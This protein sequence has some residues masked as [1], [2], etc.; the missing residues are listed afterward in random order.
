MVTNAAIA[1][2]LAATTVVVITAGIA[3][4]PAGADIGTPRTEGSDL[5]FV[6]PDGTV[7]VIPGGAVTA[8]ALFVGDTEIPDDVLVALFDQNGIQPAV[9]PAGDSGAHGNFEAL[10]PQSVGQGSVDRLD[11]LFDDAGSSFDVPPPV[12][13]QD[14]GPSQTLPHLALDLPPQGPI[15]NVASIGGVSVGAITEDA[16]PGIHETFTGADELDWGENAFINWDDRAGDFLSEYGRVPGEQSVSKTFDTL[17]AGRLELSFDLL[18]IDA[19]SDEKFIIFLDNGDAFDFQPSAWQ[20]NASGSFVTAGGLTGSYVITLAAG[21]DLVGN[22]TSDSVYHVELIIDGAGDSLTV[23]FG[24][25]LEGDF[26]QQDFGIDNIRLTSAELRADGQLTIAD[27]DPGEAAFRPASVAGDNGYG[28]FVLDASGRWTYRADNTDPRIQ[29]IGQGETVTDSFVAWSFDGSASQVVTVT[30][31][32]TNDTPRVSTF[33]SVTFIEDAGAVAVAADATL[34]DVDSPTLMGATVTVT[35]FMIGDKLDYATVDGIA[36]T[37][38]PTTGRLIFTGPASLAT[39][40]ALLRSVTFSSSSDTPSPASH[41]VQISVHDGFAASNVAN[42]TVAVTPV[43]DPPGASLPAAQ[44]VA[45][46]GALVFSAAKGNLIRVTDP[47]L[48]RLT[49]TVGVTHGTLTRATGET[50]TSLVLTGTAAQIN[51]SLAG[52][53]YQP[54]PNYSGNDTLT[55]VTSDGSATTTHAIGISVTAVADTPVMAVETLITTPVPSGHPFSLS[56]KG[57]QQLPDIAALPHGGFVAVWQEEMRLRLFDKAGQPLGDEVQVNTHT[58][59]TQRNGHVTVLEDGRIV[60]TWESYDQDG[61]AFGIYART[62]SGTGEPLTE[63]FQVNTTTA[64]NQQTPSI[65]ALS[66][67]GL[68]IT[69]S[70]W[71][72]E[73]VKYDI[74]AQRYDSTGVRVGGETLITTEAAGWQA[75]PVATLLPTG[76]YVI[77]WTNGDEGQEATFVQMRLFASNGAGGGQFALGA[78]T[79]PEMATL[80]QGGFVV[81]WQRFN[82]GSAYDVVAQVFNSDGTPR[83]GVLAVHGNDDGYQERPSVVGLPDGGFLVAWNGGARAEQ[84]IYLQRYDASGVPVGDQLHLSQ[85]GNS[86]QMA[87]LASGDVVITWY[88]GQQ[89]FAQILHASNATG[90]ENQPFELPLKVSLTDTNGTPAELLASL[91]IAGLPEGFTLEFGARDSE[92]I[93]VIDRSSTASAAWLDTIAAGGPLTVSPAYGFEGGVTV[94]V[95]ATSIEPSNGS[96]ASTTALVSVAITPA[97]EVEG[98]FALVDTDPGI[99]I[100][101]LTDNSIVYTIGDLSG[102]DIIADYDFAAGDRIDL[103]DLLDGVSPDNIADFVR[104]EDGVLSIDIDGAG[105]AGFADAVTFNQPIDTATLVFDNGFEVVVGTT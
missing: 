77:A 3:R 48:D 69:W 45:E 1:T 91:H 35:G 49:V 30:I 17:D 80:A 50:G 22:P 47:D 14:P 62:Y 59:S 39:Y 61:S 20:A 88:D 102:P 65:L 33:G 28:D 87:A 105:P 6:Q 97:P 15:N 66:D 81:T 64:A 94:S 46:D 16:L 84:G 19:W 95:T 93:W 23:G 12:T 82:V 37:Y 78:G 76:A 79:H 60:V 27:D 26:T 85:G 74:V 89:S 90:L 51:S 13:S 75:E 41:T 24:T 73:A 10:G 32:G 9:G 52:L 8:F 36:A 25:T 21:G 86:P 98:R 57:G 7:I 44:A 40:Q 38:D 103:S 70:S 99:D 83:S 4:L 101:P 72:G 43:N 92:G 63:P 2:N 29:A 104:F 31:H 5:L 18:R 11:L 71:N 53:K 54:D 100:P 42:V 96:T 56:N 67:G 34:G 68:L 55:L 58:G